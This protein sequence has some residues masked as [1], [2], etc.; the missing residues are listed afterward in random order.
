MKVQSAAVLAFAWFIP[1]S[2][3]ADETPSI[4]RGIAADKLYQ[5]GEIDS[6]DLQSGALSVAIPLGITYPVSQHLSY[7]FT[8]THSSRAW[9]YEPAKSDYWAY[10][11]RLSNSGIGWSLHFGRLLHPDDI[12]NPGTQWKYVSP[13]GGEHDFHPT[14]HASELNTAD[15]DTAANLVEYT[16]DSTYLRLKHS[17]D[18]ATQEVEFPDGTIRKFLRVG[19]TTE[20]RLDEIRDRYPAPP[21]APANWV[22]FAYPDALT[23][24]ITDSQGRSHT[25]KFVQLQYDAALKP[26]IDYVDLEAFDGTR[27]RWDF[28]YAGAGGGVSTIRRD[29]HQNS[30][31]TLSAPVLASVAPPLG[32]PWTMLHYDDALPSCR[33]SVLKEITYPSGG[34]ILYDYTTFSLPVN[35]PCNDPYGLEGQLA[36]L[37]VLTRT[38]RDPVVTNPAIADAVWSYGYALN[39]PPM[40]DLCPTPGLEA[41]PPEELTVTVT[42]PL[43]DK[44]Q[45]FF[46]VWTD[47]E[48]SLSGFVHGEY[49]LPFTRFDPVAGRFLS[50]ID[51]ECNGTGGSCLEKRYHY[52]LYDQ[53]AGVR[54]NR[55]PIVQRTIY[56]DDGGTWG[57]TAFANFDGV[58]NFRQ[59]TT[60]GTFATGNAQTTTTNFN[61][62]RGTFPGSYVV[63]NKNEPW[64][65][66]TYDQVDVT[67]GT[68]ADTTRTKYEF[69]MGTS[70]T[71]STATGFLKTVRTYKNGTAS[72]VNDLYTLFCSDTMGNVS[73][74]LYYGGD[75][76]RLQLPGTLPTCTSGAPGSGF[77]YRIDH[78][79]SG[80]VRQTSKYNGATHFLLD[81]T[82]NTRTGLPASSRDA[83]GVETQFTYDDLGRMTRSL[84]MSLG[85]LGRDAQTEYT[86]PAS[87]VVEVERCPAEATG[88]CIATNNLTYERQELTGFGQT[89]HVRRDMPVTTQK[90]VQ[91]TRYNKM[92]WKE[93]ESTW[94][95]NA[96][97]PIS[98]ENTRS[99]TVW[100]GY[101]AFGRPGVVT[102][103]DGTTTTYTYEGVQWVG[104][105]QNVAQNITGTET[106]VRRWDRFDRQGRL[107]RVEEGYACTGGPVGQISEYSFDEA[108]HLT[109]VCQNGS[110]AS[111]G[112]TRLFTYDNRGFLTSEQHPEKGG[113]SGQGTV[114]YSCFDAR[115]HNRYRDDGAT[116]RRL[117][118]T[119]DGFERLT[120]VRVPT[121]AETCGNVTET[122]TIWKQFTY[123]TANSGT[124][125]S[126]G[127]LE[128]AMSRNELGAPAF[129]AGSV[130]NVTET[131]T[132]QD[133]GGRV[134][135][136]VTAVAGAGVTSESWQTSQ[137][138]TP[139]GRLEIQYYPT[140][141]SGPGCAGGPGGTYTTTAYEDGLLKSITANGG[142]FLLS[143]ITYHPSGMPNVI[144]H[145]STG[146]MVETIT[147]AANGMARPD[148]ITITA[149][150]ETVPFTTGTY[151]YDAA[152]NI[153]TMGSDHFRYDK[154]SRL[155]EAQMASI[156]PARTQTYGFDVYGNM[157]SVATTSGPTETFQV[158]GTSNRITLPAPVALAQYDAGGN[159]T[160]W[161][162]PSTTATYTWD[163]FNRMTHWGNG[164][165]GWSY[166]YTADD[167]RLWAVKDV[168]GATYS[169]WTFR[170]LGNE[171]LVR[172]E[173]RPSPTPRALTQYAYREGKLMVS[174][175]VGGAFRD[176]GLDHLGS[177]RAT[178]ELSLGTLGVR[179]TYFPF[180]R[181]ATSTSLDAE[182]MKFTGHERDLQSTTSSTA[183]DLDYMHARFRSPLTSRFLSTDPVGGSPKVPQ[184]WNR[185]AYVRGNPLKLVDPDG[186]WP[187]MR[188]FGIGGTVHQNAIDRA[189]ET[190]TSPEERAILKNQQVVA[191]ADQSP[192]GSF[193]HAM[194]GPKET[195]EQ[196]R[197]KANAFIGSEMA[198][199]IALDR[200][201][202]RE[203][204]L[205]HVGN[206]IH[207]V[208]DSTSPAHQ[209]FATWRGGLHFN[210]AAA[211]VG[212]E[213]FDP[214][215][216][217]ELDKATS[218]VWQWFVDKK[219]PVD[220]FQPKQ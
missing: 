74:E 80:G 106:C 204:A 69:E 171:V 182:V 60:S 108:G 162:D 23:W 21:A 214:G 139:L 154:Y 81:L 137:T 25:V 24:T 192:E 200:S 111:C 188:R 70:P 114:T 37:R 120:R 159:L 121:G 201:G 107:D 216:G 94:F 126:K 112:Q 71:W 39:T 155:V 202:S 195:A 129:A 167:E 47:F 213:N 26:M 11:N 90:S 217:S 20:Y 173:R 67:G 208:G 163:L 63:V 164:A 191:D 135:N 32:S 46:S 5:V 165:E 12:A 160:S 123:A 138:T 190:V 17:A 193:K 145:S 104:T 6:V 73:N 198:A 207:L 118:Y 115:G 185:Y 57:E 68:V 54:A 40:Q 210:E 82:I 174:L 76:T 55:R 18:G 44:T 113:A 140:C 130:A 143:S 27:G 29:C 38:F 179:H 95:L 41:A 56:D 124:N 175:K 125:A 103:P 148:S 177:I 13:D 132:Y 1:L 150:N 169:N 64:I 75:G 36:V 168:A 31:G 102:R 9:D 149:P 184:S 30:G 50:S 151:A 100:S 110:G 99:A 109:K 144:T 96:D 218:Q 178:A 8:L 197:G 211:H 16:R 136:R 116:T 219:A 85:G 127:K 105:D 19:A 88:G 157:T 176:H 92:G 10:P 156:S 43:L 65:L 180:G 183:D 87:N 15:G 98:S 199:A 187:T 147:Q 58:G 42:T 209:N 34:K 134:S 122:G 86:Y 93:R 220:Y 181:E 170:G 152:G 4:G 146:S 186:R 203:E 212:A 49:G 78:T 59:T 7:S 153:K 158:I 62:T 215:A 35:D 131:Y 194:A 206:V 166:V 22:R 133:R 3:S 89:W 196:A 117:A 14:L 142:G 84:P 28:T 2:A 172:D 79:Y 51:L 45:Y 83:A 61:P 52:V 161:S 48:A 66:G 53:D 119:F 128:T 77:Q 189:L 91:L 141:V 205:G 33:Q 101:D 72:S 97:G